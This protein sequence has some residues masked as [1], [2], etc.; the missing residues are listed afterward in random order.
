MFNQDYKI[1]FDVGAVAFRHHVISDFYLMEQPVGPPG[2]Q[3]RPL[4]PRY[5]TQDT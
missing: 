2:R 1:E 4:S 3:R 5:S